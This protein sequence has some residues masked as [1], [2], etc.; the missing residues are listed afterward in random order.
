MP[1]HFAPRELSLPHGR[2]DGEERGDADVVRAHLGV[3]GLLELDRAIASDSGQ[4]NQGDDQCEADD[5]SI[6][7]RS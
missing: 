4:R 3:V 1:R 6:H 2:E 7:T 5:A